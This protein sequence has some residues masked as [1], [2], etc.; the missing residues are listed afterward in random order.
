[1]GEWQSHC[2]K[3]CGILLQPPFENET[4]PTYIVKPLFSLQCRLL[5]WAPTTL[6]KDKALRRTWL[7]CWSVQWYVESCYIYISSTGHYRS[8][9]PQIAVYFSSVTLR[10]L[11]SVSL[12]LGLPS[13]ISPHPSF[14]PKDNSL[15]HTWLCI[16][17]PQH[18]ILHSLLSRHLRCLVE[19][20]CNA[21]LQ[22]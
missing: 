8:L 13:S 2:K 5:N 12:T 21:T 15:G 16:F 1:M 4:H 18:F 6:I 11:C 7:H 3:A 14:R 20:G 9:C 19:L 10:V 22:Q 17:I